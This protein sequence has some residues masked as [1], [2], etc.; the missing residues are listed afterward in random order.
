MWRAKKS[1]NAGNDMAL[2]MCGKT[3]K[4]ELEG[5]GKVPG[6]LRRVVA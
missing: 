3:G 6:F 1:E 5:K 4:N 2:S